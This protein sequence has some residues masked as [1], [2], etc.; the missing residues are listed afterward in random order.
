ARHP[1]VRTDAETGRRALFLGRRPGSYVLGLAVDESEAL[2][3]ELWAHAT[4]ARFT[5]RHSW[6][7]GDLLMWNNL[8]VLHR[9]DAFDERSRRR[10]HRA[11]IKGDAA[12][13]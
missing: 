3:D 8:C 10:M 2:L 6:R 7:V 13:V 5:M 4:D 9:R 11:Q 12:I 1:L